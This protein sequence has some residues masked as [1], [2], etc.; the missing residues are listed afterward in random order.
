[1][2]PISVLGFP[3]ALPK[4]TDKSGVS[5]KEP[6]AEGNTNPTGISLPAAGRKRGGANWLQAQSRKGKGTS[7]TSAAALLAGRAQV[8]SEEAWLPQHP[9]AGW[10]QSGAPCLVS[11]WQATKAALLE[12]RQVHALLRLSIL[13]FHY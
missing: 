8:R 6:T 1:M 7:A 2:V 10:P 4:E 5:P 12:K 9:G 11:H 3:Q 13:G